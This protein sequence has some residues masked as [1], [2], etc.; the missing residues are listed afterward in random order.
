MNQRQRSQT[1]LNEF[2]ILHGQKD[3]SLFAFSSFNEY[4]DDWV[5]EIPGAEEGVKYNW[6]DEPNVVKTMHW[7]ADGIGEQE[8]RRESSLR[9]KL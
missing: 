3:D 4:E 9:S 7:K 2:Q 8:E 1:L 6:T 5:I